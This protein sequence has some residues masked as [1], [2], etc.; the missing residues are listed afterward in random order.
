MFG[1]LVGPPVVQSLS[2]VAVLGRTVMTAGGDVAAHH[3]ADC[4]GFLPADIAFV[5]VSSVHQLCSMSGRINLR[6]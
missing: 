1:D 4:L 3:L 5:R 2:C 6:N